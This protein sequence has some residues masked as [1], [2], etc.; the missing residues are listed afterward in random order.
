MRC[1][2]RTDI[3]E[4]SDYS[5]DIVPSP[6]TLLQGIGRPVHDAWAQSI[7]ERHR[8]SEIEWDAWM[9][10]Q[11][12]SQLTQRLLRRTGEISTEIPMDAELR[13]WAP[14]QYDR[15]ITEEEWRLTPVNIQ[16]LWQT[17]AEA[18]SFAI[19]RRSETDENRMRK[20]LQL[21]DTSERLQM[22]IESLATQKAVCLAKLS[23]DGALGDERHAD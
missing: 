15:D 22:G 10:C 9:L 2:G 5:R 13:V 17:R 1:T 6:W 14:R 11:E 12:V 8:I 18:L 16:Q 20:A 19:L 7:F 4:V 21:T 3:V 23:I